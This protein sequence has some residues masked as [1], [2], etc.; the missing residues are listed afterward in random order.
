M[1]RANGLDNRV[2]VSGRK[3]LDELS[4][5]VT[6]LEIASNCCNE[7]DLTELDLSHCLWLHRLVIG[8]NSLQNVIKFHA[9]NCALLREV[10]VGEGSL[11]MIEE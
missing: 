9:H 4:M 1:S 10:I 7:S 11:R 3:D 2:V 5:M 8:S 6:D